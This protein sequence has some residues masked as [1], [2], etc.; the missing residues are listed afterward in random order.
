[1]FVKHRLLNI[2]TDVVGLQIVLAKLEHNKNIIL[3]YHS[4]IF[5]LAVHLVHIRLLYEKYCSMYNLNG[6]KEMQVVTSADQQMELSH[7]I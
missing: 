3:S 6:F 4:K 5:Q 2:H 7:L 1:M